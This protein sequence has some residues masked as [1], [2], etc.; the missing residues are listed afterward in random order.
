MVLEYG[1]F[2]DT[3]VGINF[4]KW[5]SVSVSPSNLNDIWDNTCMINYSSNILVTGMLS[6][7]LATPVTRTKYF[8]CTFLDC[9]AIKRANQ[10]NH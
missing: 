8:T 5:V 7:L 10:T 9:F 3:A 4:K 2:A 1:G 6:G